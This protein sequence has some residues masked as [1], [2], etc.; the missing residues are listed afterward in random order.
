MIVNPVMVY[1]NIIGSILNDILPS[2]VIM[3]LLMVL[4]FVGLLINIYNA[5][6]RFRAESK[7]LAKEKNSVDQSKEKSSDE[8]RLKDDDENLGDNKDPKQVNQ[9]IEPD[10]AITSRTKM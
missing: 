2:G 10:W 6:K 8:K 5:I 7:A 1:A 3:F 4:L 9:R